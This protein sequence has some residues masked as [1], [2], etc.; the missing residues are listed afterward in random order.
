MA[1]W[2]NSAVTPPPHTHSWSPDV[3]QS[4]RPTFHPHPQQGHFSLILPQAGCGG[5][6][7]EPSHLDIGLGLGR[8]VPNVQQL[9]HKESLLCLGVW[10]W[11]PGEKEHVDPCKGRTRRGAGTSLGVAF[12]QLDMGISVLHQGLHLFPLPISSFFNACFTPPP[13]SLFLPPFLS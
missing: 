5:G 3:R 11:P 4:S 6:N 13:L 8:F 1:V 2:W 9:L 12:S 7:R 10:P